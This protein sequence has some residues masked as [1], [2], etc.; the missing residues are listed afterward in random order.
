MK[1]I[2]FLFFI[3]S[4]LT[5]CTHL[6]YDNYCYKINDFACYGEYIFTCSDF[7]CTKSQYTCHVLSLFS[8]LRGK[9]TNNYVSFMNK[10]E[11][12]SKQPK[13][14]WNKNKVC[15]NTKNCLK[16]SIHR[17][18]SSKTKLIECKCIG[19]YN[20]RCNTDYCALNKQACDGLKKKMVGIKKCDH[21][22]KK[23]N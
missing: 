13:Y 15:L 22:N 11:N 3:V 17:L 16:T 14:K 10:I 23:I 20:F 21:Y 1:N 6:K 8:N 9:H 12:C 18:W 5:E 19:K 2:I 7:L 4:K